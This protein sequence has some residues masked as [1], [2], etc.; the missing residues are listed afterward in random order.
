MAISL[1]V[2]GISEGGVY[3][4]SDVVEHFKTGD[5]VGATPKSLFHGQVI[6]SIMGAIWTSCV[7]RLF[8]SIYM[9]PSDRFPAPSAQLWLATAKVVYER[10][11]PDGVLPFVIAGFFIS[12]GLSITKILGDK[13]GW[14]HLVPSGVAIGIG[15]TYSVFNIISA[16]FPP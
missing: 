2:G 14:S 1:V 13:R 15:K 10:G 9:I 12:A 4:S 7:Y 16:P 6:G 5:L 8:T 3:Q 11:L